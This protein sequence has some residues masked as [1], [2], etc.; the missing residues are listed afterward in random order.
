[1]ITIG[2]VGLFHCYILDEYICYFG[3]LGLFC[4]FYS[5]LMENSA[6]KHYEASDLGL[7]CLPGTLL[8]LAR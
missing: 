8:W 2:T 5:I 4:H 6:S 7:H 1:M 3:L